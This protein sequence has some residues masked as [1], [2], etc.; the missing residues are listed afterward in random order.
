M[1]VGVANW[2]TL[3]YHD[4]AMVKEV[5][6]QNGMIDTYDRDPSGLARVY[7]VR[8]QHPGRP[9]AQLGRHEYDGM[10]NLVRRRIDGSV[11]AMDGLVADPVPV[12]EAG[13]RARLEEAN[14]A[15]PAVAENFYLYDDFRPA[16]AF[17][18]RQHPATRPI[19]TIPTRT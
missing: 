3:T 15:P 7:N 14:A 19:R 4:N 8:V 6:H 9:P 12:D 16:E 2:A 1:L 17:Q 10:G 11:A 5:R 18:R 13:G